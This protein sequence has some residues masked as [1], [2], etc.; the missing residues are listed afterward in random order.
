V[1]SGKRS[2]DIIFSFLSLFVLLPLFSIIAIVIFLSYGRPILF[3]QERPGKNGRIFK[4]IKFRTMKAITD[5][6]LGD[7]DRITPVG[8][9]LRSSSLDE[10]PELYNVLIGD[11]S[12]V[13]PRP[14]L[15][16]YLD[17]YSE[18]QSRRHETKPGITGWAQVN[19]R[20]SISWKEKFELDVW[21]VDNRSFLLDVKII[22]ITMKK[23]LQRD[24]IN[25]KD[26]A[27]MSKFK[28]NNEDK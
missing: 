4:L 24:G 13:G 2:F 10:L 20:N 21:Y 7:E 5:Q 6:A 3:I 16:E 8:R 17:L 28:G 12:F 11:M 23:I 1:I 15:V 22:I 18:F 27:T 14:L 9:L 25:S 19:G 26:H